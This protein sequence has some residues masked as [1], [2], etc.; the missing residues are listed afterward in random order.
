[1]RRNVVSWPDHS[2]TAT[3]HPGPAPFGSVLAC[4]SGPPKTSHESN[5]PLLNLP[6]SSPSPT[7]HSSS[8]SYEPTT[9]IEHSNPASTDNNTATSPSFPTT[10]SI[11]FTAQP[12]RLP[13]KMPEDAPYD[14]YIPTGQAA[15]QQGAGGNARTQA[16]QAVSVFI[17]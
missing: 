16:L 3:V 17:S 5:K 10:P 8:P 12:V 1:V 13:T 4:T 15:P 2:G 11:P 7:T 9:P 14:P 6:T